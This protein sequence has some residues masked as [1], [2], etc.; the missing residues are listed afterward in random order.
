MIIV[1]NALRDKSTQ[2]I[3]KEFPQYTYLYKKDNLGFTGGNNVSIKYA[4]KK[5]TDFI[6]ISVYI[7]FLGSE[8]S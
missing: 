5:V 2:R 4:I 6:F 1:D 8:K 3:Q 7:L